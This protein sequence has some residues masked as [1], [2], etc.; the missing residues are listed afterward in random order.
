MALAQFED[1]IMGA[2]K[3]QLAGVLARMGDTADIDEA[4]LTGAGAR[5]PQMA[6][7]GNRLMLSQMNAD[8]GRCT[9]TSVIGKRCWPKGN[10]PRDAAAW[11]LTKV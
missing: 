5:L 9:E 1:V 7:A 3:A 11:P 10:E 8:P 6:L 4:V 2:V